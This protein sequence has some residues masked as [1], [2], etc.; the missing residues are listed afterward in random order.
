MNDLNHNFKLDTGSR[1]YLFM[2]DQIVCEEEEEKKASEALDEVLAVLKKHKLRIQDLILLYGNLGYSIGA[3]IEGLKE[4]PS[5]EELQKL[6]YEKP[7][8]GISLMLQG[9][10]TTSWAEDYIKQQEGKKDGK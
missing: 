6:Y 5:L 4:G 10:L 3:S 1:S 2:T 8:I 9:M 7:S